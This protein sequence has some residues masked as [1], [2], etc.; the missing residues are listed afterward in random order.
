MELFFMWEA[1]YASDSSKNSSDRKTRREKGI[2][3]NFAGGAGKRFGEFLR[4]GIQRYGCRSIC[5][6]YV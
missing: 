6:V 4:I 1:K 2:S 5:F 3:V